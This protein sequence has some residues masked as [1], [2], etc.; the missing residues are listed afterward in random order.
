[1][2]NIIILFWTY[3]FG[4]GSNYNVPYS[5]SPVALPKIDYEMMFFL[6]WWG[7]TQSVYYHQWG[8]CKNSEGHDIIKHFTRFWVREYI[9]HGPGHGIDGLTRFLFLRSF[10]SLRVHPPGM[11]IYWLGS[12]VTIPL[13]HSV[14]SGKHQKPLSEWFGNS[15]IEWIQSWQEF[16]PYHKHPLSQFPSLSAPSWSHLS[17]IQNQY[18]F[19]PS[20]MVYS[21]WLRRLNLAMLDDTLV[22]SRKATKFIT[23]GHSL[24]FQEPS[25]SSIIGFNKRKMGM[26]AWWRGRVEEFAQT[27]NAFCLMIGNY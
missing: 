18:S 14:L 3:L 17:E 23:R 11:I 27:V 20:S 9:Y 8:K 6:T 4:Y 16:D 10:Y 2:S 13:P 21:V 24:F 5:R 15:L 22:C 12:Y 7:N 25:T 26:W 1:M 19:N